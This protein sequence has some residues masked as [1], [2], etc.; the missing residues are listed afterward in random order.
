MHFY[1]LAAYSSNIRW[2]GLTEKAFFEG[3]L[4]GVT[5]LY[6]PSDEADEFLSLIHI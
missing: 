5:V 4:D 2:H 1:T 6:E 3:K